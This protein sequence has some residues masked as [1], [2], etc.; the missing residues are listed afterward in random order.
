[1]YREDFDNFDNFDFTSMDK[2]VKS[3]WIAALRSN[4]YKQ[5]AG[6]LRNCK[7]KFCC[8]GVLCDIN[9]AKAIKYKKEGFYEYEYD[10]DT[11]SSELPSTLSH[12]VKMDLSAIDCLM[13]LND[14]E[15][16]SFNE[17]A[18]WIEKKL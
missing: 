7:D 5:G 9:D 12:K 17:I 15:Q 2:E 16:W 8:L 4:K 3:K 13:V 18:D 6:Q 1:M 11:S 10:G 14:I